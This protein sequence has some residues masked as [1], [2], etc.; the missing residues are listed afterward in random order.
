MAATTTCANALNCRVYLDT[1]AGVLTDISGSSASVEMSPSSQIGDFRVFLSRWRLRQVGGSDITFVLNTVYTTAADEGY[2]IIRDWYWGPNWQVART[3]QF[4][5][6][7]NLANS[8]RITCEVHLAEIPMT[9]D[10][11]DPGPI[12]VTATL[13]PTGDVVHGTIGS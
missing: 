9:L 12:M 1:G 4:D 10:P 5:I 2:D 11:D 6:P 8:E 7:K 13:M 3:V